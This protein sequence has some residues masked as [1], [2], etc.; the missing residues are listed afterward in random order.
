MS[1]TVHHI[2]YTR[3]RSTQER[4]REY[5]ELIASGGNCW[6]S[7]HPL[8]TTME[9][10]TLYDLRYSAAEVA[11]A[12]RD[13]RRPRP[14]K[15]RHRLEAYEYP[16]SYGLRVIGGISNRQER[17]LRAAD[18]VMDRRVRQMLRGAQDAVEA[19]WDVDFPDPRHRHFGVWDSW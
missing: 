9:W 6:M 17:G 15:L 10:H 19:A 16:R 5:E 14:T 7:Y 13:G 18:R 1:R 4:N 12:E 3:R 2:V 11:K 8:F